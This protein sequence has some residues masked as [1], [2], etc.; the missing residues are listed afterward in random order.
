MEVEYN[1]AKGL[2]ILFYTKVM[3]NINDTKTIG[4]SFYVTKTKTRS[5]L[6]LKCVSGTSVIKIVA[7]AR[8]H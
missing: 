2:W 4:E 5:L 7:N 8:D 3:M 6:H 1:F